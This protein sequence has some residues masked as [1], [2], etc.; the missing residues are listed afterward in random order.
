LS[1]GFWPVLMGLAPGTGKNPDTKTDDGI[2]VAS[3]AGLPWLPPAASNLSGRSHAWRG[4]YLD[5]WVGGCVGSDGR[6]CITARLEAFPFR[7]FRCPEAITARDDRGC[8]SSGLGVWSERT[9]STTGVGW[10]G[11]N[12]SPDSKSPDFIPFLGVLRPSLSQK[13]LKRMPAGSSM[14]RSYQAQTR[15][16]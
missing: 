3:Q 15:P 1:S 9:F 10:F 7:I 6:I 14:S 11:T 8:G 5:A 12:S 16:R 13:K 2:V 4:Q